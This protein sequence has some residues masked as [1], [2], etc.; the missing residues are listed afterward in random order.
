MCQERGVNH[1]SDKAPGVLKEVCYLP[2]KGEVKSVLSFVRNG[3]SHDEGNGFF[4]QPQAFIRCSCLL[5]PSALGSAPCWL[6]FWAAIGFQARLHLH[7]PCSRGVGN[8]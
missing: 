4:A 8:P 5:F 6:C 2:V 3:E 7:V 1:S